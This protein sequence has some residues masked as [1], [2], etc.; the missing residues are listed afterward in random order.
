LSRQTQLGSG[1][2]ALRWWKSR[3]TK[4]LK[5]WTVYVRAEGPENVDTPS[6]DHSL[7]DS[8]LGGVIKGRGHGPRSVSVT[9][10]VAAATKQAAYRVV[11][12][13][14]RGVLGPEWTVEA[15]PAAPG[16]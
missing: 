9:V 8:D 7:G 13:K 11:I 16:D 3:G 15:D 10:E 5:P 4:D 12:A 1:G 14:V 6:V 2:V